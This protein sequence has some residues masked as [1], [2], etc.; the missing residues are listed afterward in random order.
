VATSR[1]SSVAPSRSSSAA[2]AE[3]AGATLEFDE[4]AEMLADGALTQ[5]DFDIL[6]ADMTRTEAPVAEPHA[7]PQAPPLGVPPQV[8]PEALVA[9]RAGLTAEKKPPAPVR[10]AATVAPVAA[11]AAATAPDLPAAAPVAAAA[12]AAPQDTEGSGAGSAAEVALD[13]VD[14]GDERYSF[15][16]RLQTEGSSL[17]LVHK[18]KR[19]S[20]GE[21]EKL[22]KGVRPGGARRRRLDAKFGGGIVN[23]AFDPRMNS[24]LNADR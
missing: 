1:P 4:L 9:P 22:V 5:E 23:E 15:L 21:T 3:A 14:E 18:G 19:L 24:W 6:T 10:P 17:S 11:A 7:P 12:P 20:A 13:S 8:P 16:R 2:R